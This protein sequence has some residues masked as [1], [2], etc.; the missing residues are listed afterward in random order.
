MAIVAGRW[1]P[2]SATPDAKVLLT[3]RSLRGFAD[4]AVSVLLPSYLITIGFSSGQVGA[5][6]FG[7]LLGSAA[8]TLS[9]G[10]LSHTLGRKPVLVGACALM[11]ATGMGFASLRTFWTLF[12]V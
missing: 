1:I 10:L 2:R 7:T 4:G 6:V 9:V 8:L 12:A 11:L 3:T 5:I